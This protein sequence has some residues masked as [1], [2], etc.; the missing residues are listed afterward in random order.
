MANEYKGFKNMPDEINEMQNLLT[1][2]QMQYLEEIR[3]INEAAELS[4]RGLM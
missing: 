4:G 2:R 1:Q 3:E